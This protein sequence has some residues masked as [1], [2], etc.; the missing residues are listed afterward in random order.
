MTAM[1]V[2][3]TAGDGGRA[4]MAVRT[5]FDSKT[6]MEQVLAGGVEEGMRMVMAQIEAVLA[7]TPA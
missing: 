4:V 5:S 1:I 6:G 2:T 3:I 7:G